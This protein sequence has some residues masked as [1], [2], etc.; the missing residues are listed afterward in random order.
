[1][2]EDQFSVYVTMPTGATLDATDAVVVEAEN[3]VMEIAERKDV[4]SKIQQE[5]AILTVTLLE[6]L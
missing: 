2:E 1:M 5:E 3:R 4:I 6:G